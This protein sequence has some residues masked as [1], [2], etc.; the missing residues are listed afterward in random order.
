MLVQINGCFFLYAGNTW[1]VSTHMR[2]VS[3]KVV[4]YCKVRAWALK[5]PDQGAG[6][7]REISKKDQGITV[8]VPEGSFGGEFV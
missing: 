6:Y 4:W 2:R 5:R 8:Q 1:V 3:Y 7:N